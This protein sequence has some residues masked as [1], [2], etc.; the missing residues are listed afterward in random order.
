MLALP[1][2]ESAK[3]RHERL[4]FGG[5]PK[6]RWRPEAAAQLGGGVRA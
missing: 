4:G 3:S 2:F 1:G 5:F 6:L